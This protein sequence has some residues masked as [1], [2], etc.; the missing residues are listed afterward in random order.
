MH[1]KFFIHA[2]GW[3]QILKTSKGS[4]KVQSFH[5]GNIVGCARKFTRGV[6]MV[7]SSKKI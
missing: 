5:S 7:D 2:P 6:P 1:L 4:P 3:R